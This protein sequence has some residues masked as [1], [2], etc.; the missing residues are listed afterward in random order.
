MKVTINC[1]T[2]LFEVTSLAL[3]VCH[4]MGYGRRAVQL[5]QAYYEGKRHSLSEQNSHL[6]TSL[7]SNV[8]QVGR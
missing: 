5:L 2:L 4:Q 3:D 1:N 7:S 8:S 6:A